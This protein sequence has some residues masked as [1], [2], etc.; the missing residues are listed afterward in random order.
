MANQKKT[1]LLTRIQG[2]HTNVEKIQKKETANGTKWGPI[3]SFYCPFNVFYYDRTILLIFLLLCSQQC[4]LCK[5]VGTYS[6]GF[7]RA[8][9]GCYH[10]ENPSVRGQY[11]VQWKP[12]ERPLTRCFP[13]QANGEETQAK[14]MAWRFPDWTLQKGKFFIFDEEASYLH[15]VL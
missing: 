2:K 6:T 13:G 15:K 1:N 10:G 7:T 8:P 12:I 3:L 4:R 11:C 5:L 14:H 9:I